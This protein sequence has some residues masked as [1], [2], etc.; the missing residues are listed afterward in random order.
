MRQAA[1]QPLATEALRG[2]TTLVMSPRKSLRRSFIYS[3]KPELP[4]QGALRSCALDKRSNR[5]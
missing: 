1:G 3:A 4:H 2:L 5:S